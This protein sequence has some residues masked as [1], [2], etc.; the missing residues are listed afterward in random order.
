VEAVRRVLAQLAERGHGQHIWRGAREL[1]AIP[2]VAGR[3]D[4]PDPALLGLADLL[5]QQVGTLP[6][7]EAHVDDVDALVDAVVQRVEQVA[8]LPAREDL[9]HPHVRFRGE[10]MDAGCADRGSHQPAAV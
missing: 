3:D 9:H 2:G 7:A 4:A 5:Q 10:P 6:A 8:Q 1:D